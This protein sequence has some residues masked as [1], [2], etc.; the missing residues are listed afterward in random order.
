MR[1]TLTLAVI[2][3]GACAPPPKMQYASLLLAKEVPNGLVVLLAA[4]IQ[5]PVW[6]VET[7]VVRRACGTI[8]HNAQRLKNVG[9][10]PSIRIYDID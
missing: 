2:L 5:S 4:C 8:N 3:C 6:F 1:S 10:A 7:K 9:S